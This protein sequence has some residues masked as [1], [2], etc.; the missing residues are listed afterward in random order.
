MNRDGRADRIEIDD[1]LSPKIH[2][3]VE[4]FVDTVLRGRG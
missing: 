3:R 2:D 4:D 1:H